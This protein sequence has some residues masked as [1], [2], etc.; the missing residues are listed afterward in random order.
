MGKV[1]DIK[2]YRNIRKTKEAEVQELSLEEQYIRAHKEVIREYGSLEEY[3]KQL[4][5]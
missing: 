5:N 4:Y 2:D 1:V 3:Y